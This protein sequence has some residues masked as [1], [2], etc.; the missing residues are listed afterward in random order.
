MIYRFTMRDKVA[1]E[2]PYLVLVKATAFA[3]RHG[4]GYPGGIPPRKVRDFLI[5][6]SVV[7]S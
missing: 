2:D 3:I 4:V 1:V 7:S 5:K 6:G